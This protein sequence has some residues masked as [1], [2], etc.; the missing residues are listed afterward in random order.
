MLSGG[1]QS[2]VAGSGMDRALRKRE[3]GRRSDF[4]GGEGAASLAACSHAAGVF[5]ALVTVYPLKQDIEREVTSENAK[6]QNHR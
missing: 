3:S 6:R 4:F 2:E 5:C 1:A